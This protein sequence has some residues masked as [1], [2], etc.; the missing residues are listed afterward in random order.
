MT[1]LIR[2]LSRRSAAVSPINAMMA[3]AA[4]IAGILLFRWTKKT[5]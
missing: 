5:D 1:S 4:L 2:R 3:A